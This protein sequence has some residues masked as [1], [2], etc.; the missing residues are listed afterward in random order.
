VAKQRLGKRDV[1]DVDKLALAGILVGVAGLA[2]FAI[3]Q[4]SSKS[5]AAPPAPQPAPSGSAG[6][7]LTPGHRYQVNYPAG[8]NTPTTSAQIVS[9][10]QTIGAPVNVVSFTQAPGGAITFVFD[11]TG[12]SALAVPPLQNG[13]SIVDMGLSPTS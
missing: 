12:S 6:V 5:P 9:G 10:L 1:V 2:I 3:A 13:A 11:Y 7:T 4:A 8:P